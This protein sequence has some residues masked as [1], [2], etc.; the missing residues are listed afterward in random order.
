MRSLL[1][2]AIL[3]AAL[4]AAT[5]ALADDWTVTKLRGA[6][7]AMDNGTWKALT[8]GDAVPDGNMIRTLADGHL[9]LQRG[10]EVVTLGANTEITIADKTGQRYTTVRQD[11]GSVEVEAEVEN[12]QHFEVDTKFLAAV[13]K[14]THFIVTAD[15]L[16]ASVTVDRG[17]VA[18]ESLASRRSTTV[19]LGQTASVAR[20]TD[21]A[22]SGG[23]TLPAIFS[24]DGSVYQPPGGVPAQSGQATTGGPAGGSVP[25]PAGAVQPPETSPPITTAVLVNPADSTAAMRLRGSLGSAGLSDALSKTVGVA[26]V[27]EQPINLVTILIGLLIGIVVGALALA[28]R[29]FI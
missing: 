19:T 10:Q 21:L 9:D 11:F 12:V 2:L 20:S 5:P 26:P 13:V 28:L 29:R 24:P 25:A 18:V 17:A 8:R 22:V 15:A 14:G 16:G 1:L 3:G 6:A 4:L 23:G 27:K 7:Q